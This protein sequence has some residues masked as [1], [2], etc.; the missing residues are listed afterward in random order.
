MP[1]REI[2]I[3]TVTVLRFSCRSKPSQRLARLARNGSPMKKFGEL[4]NFNCSLL[5]API[6]F[7][8]SFVPAVLV[9]TLPVVLRF[10][11]Y[12]RTIN[13]FKQKEEGNGCAGKDWIVCALST[14]EKEQVG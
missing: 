5:L 12:L 3:I 1:V 13:C 2:N 4:R 9:P 6:I 11:S 8:L 14:G 10:L 7:V